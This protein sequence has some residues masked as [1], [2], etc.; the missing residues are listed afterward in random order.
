MAILTKAEFEKRLSGPT[1][2]RHDL[3]KVQCATC[4]KLHEAAVQRKTSWRRD[5]FFC[6]L[7]CGEKYLR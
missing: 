5:I 6:S 2:Q 3:V 4:G 7:K 1:K